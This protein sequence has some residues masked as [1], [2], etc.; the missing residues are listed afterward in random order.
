MRIYAY[1]IRPGAGLR[2]QR[3]HRKILYNMA[4]VQKKLSSNTYSNI[5][6]KFLDELSW[7]QNPFAF[8]LLFTVSIILFFT[9]DLLDI[10]LSTFL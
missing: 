6:R 8:I 7:H 3:L 1:L 2:I 5:M 10:G 4:R 9:F